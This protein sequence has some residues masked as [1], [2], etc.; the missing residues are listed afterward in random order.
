MAPSPIFALLT[1]RSRRSRYFWL[2]LSMVF[3]V[4]YGG[5]ALQQAFASDYVV[6]DDARQHIFWMQRFLDS[7]LFPD[8]LI[9]DYFQAAAPIG[10]EWLYRSLTMLGI[11]PDWVSK[12]LPFFLGVITVGYGFFLSLEIF[13]LPLGA[14][15]S[16]ALLNQAIWGSDEI[17]S[18]TPRAFL[19]PLLL[20]FL[21]YLL[22]QVRWRS[23]LVLVLQ[24]I[25]Y[26]PIILIS[27][28]VLVLRLAQW[29]KGRLR[30]SHDWRDYGL[31]AAGMALI[32]ALALY[33]GNLSEFGSIVSRAEAQTMPEFQP[34]GRNAFFRSDIAFWLDGYPGRSGI[35]HRRTSIPV[36]SWVG[37][38]L[39]W[40]LWSPAKTPLRRLVTPHVRVLGQLLVVSFGLFM[41]AHLLLFELHLPSRYTS[42]TIRVVLVLAAGMVWVFLFEALFKWG[43]RWVRSSTASGRSHPSGQLKRLLGQS[44]PLLFVAAFFIATFFYYP[45]F[46]NN[47]P[48]TAYYNLADSSELYE[49]FQQQPKDSLIASLS[50]EAS[51]LP[52]FAGRSI[53]V[54][55]EHGLAYHTEYYRQFRQRVIDLLNAQYTTDPAVVAAFIQQYGVDFWL[56]DHHA[57]APTYVSDSQWM[58]QFQPAADQAT[59]HVAQGQVPIVS[60]AVPSCSVFQSD[61]WTVLDADCVVRFA[62]SAS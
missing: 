26:P 60:Q 46:L 43:D 53:L 36:T 61:R 30:L 4:I 2:G 20:A 29:P 52:S 3:A 56:L 15:I 32:L 40:F 59:E 55:E 34:G 44:L 45:L 38:L 7:E 6:Q 39:P 10:Y 1:E 19:Y 35:F 12:V 57:F 17:S 37:L 24:A 42:H 54:S 27:V 41:L 22:R 14:F 47:Y 11:T 21:Y 9:A 28:G 16:S 5:L 48:K 49:F 33:T 51:N 18:A 62:Q 25:F 58:R 23:G 50:N 31:V 8:D 13:P